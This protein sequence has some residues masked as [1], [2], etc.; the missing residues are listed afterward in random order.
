[1]SEKRWRA[2]A[3]DSNFLE[4]PDNDLETLADLTAA[5]VKKHGRK[6]DWAEAMKLR[7]ASDVDGNVDGMKLLAEKW[8]AGAYR[9]GRDHLPYIVHPAAVVAMLRDWGYK[10]YEDGLTL[11]VAWGHDLLEDT[12]VPRE[13]IV[14]ACSRRELG[15]MVLA[16]IAMLTFTPPKG[17]D[18]AAYDQAKAD[19]IKNV[20]A[21]APVEI[22]AVKI[23]D[24]LCNTLDFA[25]SGNPRAAGYL[26]DGAALFARIGELK[27]ADRARETLEEVSGRVV[28]LAV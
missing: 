22:L 12:E 23:A 6:P 14:A 11:S 19:Y 15:E 3:G 16:G 7:Y 10:D 27:H 1:M 21:G 28:G 4:D 17:V 13:D 25:R 9:R 26:A 18:D 8:H 5:F 20:G 2:I 24:R